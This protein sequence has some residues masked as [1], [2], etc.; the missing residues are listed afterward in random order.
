VHEIFEE[1]VLAGDLCDELLV[2]SHETL[3]CRALLRPGRGL[4]LLK[5]VADRGDVMLRLE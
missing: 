4:E 5:D 3:E 1:L 2:L